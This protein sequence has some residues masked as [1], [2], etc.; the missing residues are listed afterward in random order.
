MIRTAPPP[1]AAPLDTALWALDAGL[2][3]VTLHPCGATIRTRD[4]ER[5]ATGKEPI[6]VAWGQTRPTA[7]RLRETT[8]QNP[9]AGV[10]LMLGPDAGVI[11]VECDGE[12]G[13]ESVRALCGGDAPETLSWSSRRGCHRL[14]AWDDRLA[15]LTSGTLHPPGHP[16]L[17]IRIGGAGRQLQS[18]IPPT[19]GEDGV[20]REWSGAS[21]IARLPDEVIERIIALAMPQPTPQVDTRQRPPTPPTSDP[22][23]AWFRKALQGEAGR[24]AL[25]AEGTRH[26]GLLAA[27]R[28]L[29][30]MLHHGYLTEADVIPELA[31]AARRTGLG[32]AETAETIRDGL[33]YGQAAPLPWP[34][35]LDRPKASRNGHHTTPNGDGRG[36]ETPPASD[37]CDASPDPGKAG[38]NEAPDDPH[39]LSRVY[40][41]TRCRHEDGLTLRSWR[42]ESLR[43]DGA[44]RSVLDR[45]LN[46]DLGTATKAEFDRLNV[47]EVEAWEGAPQ[48]GNGKPKPKPTTRKVSNNLVGNVALALRGYTALDARTEAPAWLTDDPPFPAGEVLPTRNALVHL[49][50]LI[51]GTD[52]VRPPT[53][54]FFCSYVLDYDFDR[55]AP[56]PIDWLTFLGARPVTG[57]S[58]IRLQLW[59]DDPESIATLQEWFG[60]LLLPDTRLEKIL[61]LIGPR[62]SGKGTIGRVLRRVIGPENMA[63]PTLSGLAGPFGL[64]PLIGKPAAIISD[65]RLSG[66]SD[67]AVIVERLLSISGE[68][69]LTIDRK[70]L[71]SW[72]GKLPTRFT[73]ISNE[74]PRLADSSGAMAGRLI[75]L[76]LTRSFHG[77]EDERLTDVLTRELPGIL[78]WA[79]E[80]WRRLQERGH[81]VQPESGREMV[82]EM[83]DLASPIGAFIKER[84]RI[85][86]GLD[87]MATRLYAAWKEWC[88]EKGRDH[89]GDEQRF[90]RDLRAVFP[91][92]KVSQHRLDD[93]TRKRFYEGIGLAADSSF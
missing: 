8:R 90:G 14:Y 60:Y 65:A 2:W 45:D 92:L 56:E 91:A 40:L 39:R 69:A 9:G 72:T 75:L 54:L 16:D 63:G 61:A 46:A 52:A 36:G 62:R 47:L 82:E 73:L 20:R 29:G 6:G 22:A 5:R 55:A 71:P 7:E 48:E 38:P 12:R 18:A 43:W 68:D 58:R 37:A 28:T 70:H 15:L 35:A 13:E 44:Y 32:E 66:R 19:L 87:V 89:S 85:E 50:G 59:P 49:P 25:A 10:G 84:C 34:D 64:A 88:V 31:H 4:G 67:Q 93:G 26:A 41:D 76:R 23:A 83:E 77:K 42:G 74:L 86:T 53:P 79:I 11:D 30:G 27:A 57:R 21:E 80:G 33:A 78:L 3:P 24:V 51:A 17:E 81:F 1:S